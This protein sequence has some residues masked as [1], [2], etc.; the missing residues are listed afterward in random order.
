MLLDLDNAVKSELYLGD[1]KQCLLDYAKEELGED[2]E[3]RSQVLQD[4]R[5]MIYGKYELHLKT[6][7]FR[8]CWALRDVLV[9]GFVVILM[10]IDYFVLE[11]GECVPHRTDD[12]FL[13]RFLRARNYT[14]K[15]AHRLVNIVLYIIIYLKPCLEPSMSNWS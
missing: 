13:L 11:R 12:A 15:M 2:P 6:K 4:L 7:L 8:K 9:N 1:P 5:D 14:V 10:L 3:T